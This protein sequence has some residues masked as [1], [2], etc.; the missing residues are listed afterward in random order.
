MIYRHSNEPYE[1]GE[2][3]PNFEMFLIRNFWYSD[4]Y[5]QSK[6]LY[7]VWLQ[8]KGP[9][10]NAKFRYFSKP[11]TLGMQSLTCDKRRTW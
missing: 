10:K 8:K 9:E 4:T 3:C 6:S 5:L 7:S 2:K 11:A 1:L